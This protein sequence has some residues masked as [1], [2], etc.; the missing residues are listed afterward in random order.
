[1]EILKIYEEEQLSIKYDLIRHLI[2]L[3][4]QGMMDINIG[5][6]QRFR[7]FLIKST[8]IGTAIN[9]ENQQLAKELHTPI[10]TRFKK[11]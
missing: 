11:C 8:H 1:M 3:E 6:L 9:F 10:I 5:L 2:L 4:T 7:N